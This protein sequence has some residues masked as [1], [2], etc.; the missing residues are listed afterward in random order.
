MHP[1]G[2]HVR[3]KYNLRT[4]LLPLGQ[5]IHQAVPC[6]FLPSDS[7][8]KTHSVYPEM[9]TFTRG[10]IPLDQTLSLFSK[11]IRLFKGEN[12]QSRLWKKNVIN[13]KKFYRFI[14]TRT[15]YMGLVLQPNKINKKKI[16]REAFHIKQSFPIKTHRIFPLSSVFIVRFSFRHTATPVLV[17]SDWC[18]LHSMILAWPNPRR[19]Q[20]PFDFFGPM[21]IGWEISARAYPRLIYRTNKK[22]QQQM[23]PTSKWSEQ[24]RAVLY[25]VKGDR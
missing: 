4:T 9:M 2:Q 14:Y 20:I 21:A 13:T 24:Y 3:R 17:L 15:R 6:F 7:N 25:C 19:S 8:P 18:I 5:L 11:L 1:F 22:L 23:S 10:S 12:Y 16:V